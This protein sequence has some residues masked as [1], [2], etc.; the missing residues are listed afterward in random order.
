[1][2]NGNGEGREYSRDAVLREK[3]RHLFEVF[4]MSVPY[5]LFGETFF[6]D[7]QLMS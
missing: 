1:M 2:E 5:P 3:V 4:A 7:L 6:R